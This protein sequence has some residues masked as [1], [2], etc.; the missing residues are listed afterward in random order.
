MST[1]L[2]PV[3]DDHVPAENRDSATFGRN[4]LPDFEGNIVDGARLSITGGRGLDVGD[5]V[6]AID[7]TVHLYVQGRVTDVQHKVDKASG[8]LVRI[9]VIAVM[10]AAQLPGDFD[11]GE[12]IE[13]YQS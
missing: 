9:H 1:H 4:G 2:R 8:A 11:P 5:E 13:T 12:V 3:N 6:N 10:E 7:D